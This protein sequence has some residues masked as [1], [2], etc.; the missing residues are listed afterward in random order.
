MS[1][2]AWKIAFY[3]STGLI[4]ASMLFGGYVDFTKNPGAIEMM[5]HL[6]YPVYF[7]MIIGAAKI[8]GVIGLWQTK[9]PFLREWAYAGFF[10]DLIGALIS[11]SA[12]GDGAALY[13]PALINL[14]ILL[15][16]YIAF[17][18]LGY[19]AK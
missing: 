7:A 5:T 1:S 10:F 15:V 17:R 8:L 4:S 12:V 11:H 13:A 6:G 16:S 18:K 3:I 2:K 19:G 14:M 9:V